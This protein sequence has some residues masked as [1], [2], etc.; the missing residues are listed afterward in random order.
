MRLFKSE[1]S[2]LSWSTASQQYS[3]GQGWYDLLLAVNPEDADDVYIGDAELRRST[4]GGNTFAYV[5]GPYSQQD[6]HVDYHCMVFAPSNPDIRYVGCDGGIY[7]STDNGNSWKDLNTGLS[8]IQFYR[9]AAHPEDPNIVFGGA[10]DNSN[11]RTTD[12]GFTWG[13]VT[14]ADG[15]ECFVD[16]TNPENVYMSVQY[17][18]LYKSTHGGSYNSFVDITP[19]KG[20]QTSAWLC[21]TLFTRSITILYSQLRID[22]GNQQTPDR[23]GCR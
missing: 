17:G 4:N 14:F 3:S 5:G 16:H 1:N 18:T 13:T 20:D 19:D 7:K 9:I 12:G 21:P 2:G 10:Q 23:I 22:H 11:Y 8:T 6:M 15:M